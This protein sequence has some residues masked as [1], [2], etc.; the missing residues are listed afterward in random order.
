MFPF[1]FLIYFLIH[2]NHV[3]SLNET[4]CDLWSKKHLFN[5]TEQHLF[6]FTFEFVQIETVNDLHFGNETCSP[7]SNR[8]NQLQ[9]VKIFSTQMILI[10]NDLDLERGV[11][12]LFQFSLERKSRKGV[13]FQNIKGLSYNRRQ[14]LFE[15]N[16]SKTFIEINLRNAHFNFYHND[17]LITEEDCVN[18]SFAENMSNFFR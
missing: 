16:R 8:A 3:S 12:S 6:N 15:A 9:V 14:R 10:P 17:K 7:R 5:S 2:L 1:C 11:L 18:G 13:I 4:W